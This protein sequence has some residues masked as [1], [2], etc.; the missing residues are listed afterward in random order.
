MKFYL[1]ADSLTE[2]SQEDIQK[3]DHQY[4]AVVTTEEYRSISDIFKMGV[5][6][7][8]DLK[9]IRDTKAVVNYDS[10][11]GTFNIPDH[12]TF[13]SRKFQL[14]FLLDER[15]IVFVD[16]DDYTERLLLDIQHSRKWKLPSLE[17]FVYDFLEE[18]IK[19]DLRML[20]ALEEELNIMETQIMAGSI[21]EYPMQLNEIRTDLLDL[22]KHYEHLID[23]AKE[24]E[25][26]ENG[27]F[28]EKNL[29]YFRLFTERVER[30]KDNVTQLR[31]FIVQLRDLVSGQ[32]SIKQNHIMTLLTIVT[33]IFMPLTLIVGWY[34]M[35]FRYMPE[36][37]W[38]LGYPVVILCSLAIVAALLI[39]FKKKKWL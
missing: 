19:N 5:D 15:G 36:L 28:R 11:M 30:L 20:D 22:Y 34:G 3:G 10:L 14:A 13:S 8:M 31:D 27:F 4:V 23:L 7:D 39:W 21:E 6:I 37:D 17:R 18:T 35:N 9:R 25:E 33:S 1:I 24:L 38:R 2:C 32:L 29:R 26:N 16:D 12:E